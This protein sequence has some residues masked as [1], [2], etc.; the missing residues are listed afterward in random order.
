MKKLCIRD[1][2]DTAT[3]FYYEVGMTYEFEEGDAIAETNHF[4]NPNQKPAVQ[5]SEA[6]L[7]PALARKTMKYL[8]KKYPEAAKKVDLRKRGAHR[9]LVYEIMKMQGTLESTID[10]G[11]T[12]GE[13]LIEEKESKL[14]A[15]LKR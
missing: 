5:E 1:C 2:F 3:N 9:S 6:R 12:Q 8:A 7:D 4:V 10:E 15:S 14:A 13:Y 11:K